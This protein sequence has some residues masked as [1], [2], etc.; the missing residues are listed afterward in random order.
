MT[1]NEL[2]ARVVTG[3]VVL[4]LPVV[5]GALALGGLAA[6]LGVVAG[7]ALALGNFRWLA[8]TALG[9]LGAGEG[10][11]RRAWLPWTVLRF[12]VLVTAAAALLLSGWAHPAGV[13][14]GLTVPICALVV[15]GLRGGP[16]EGERWA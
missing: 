6:A 9:V 8:A 16:D 1:P 12:A 5:A 10:E 14:I 7:G 3:S 4:T 11:G 2:A 15:A 13:L